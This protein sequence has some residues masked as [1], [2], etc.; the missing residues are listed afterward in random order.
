M[1]PRERYLSRGPS[2]TGDAELLALVLGTGVAG[3]SAMG[4]AVDVLQ[5][6]GGLRGV[7]DAGVH[8]LQQMR[9]LGPARAVRVHAALQAGRRSLH[10]SERGQAISSPDS[11]YRILGP[12]LRGQVDEELHGLFLDR[13]RRLVAHRVLTR[14]SD[15]FTV[16]DPRQVFRVAVQTGA[17]AIVLGHNHPSDDP[18]PSTQDREVTHRVATAGRML[19]VGLLDH[20]VIGGDRYVSLAQ[21]GLIPAWRDADACW[22]A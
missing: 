11:A 5:R 10:A 22:T 21:E 17:C 9:G 14:G 19:G 6:F 1:Q 8:E 12:A 13:R 15:A 16:V 3:K 7:A 18:T 4:L 2:P 20:L